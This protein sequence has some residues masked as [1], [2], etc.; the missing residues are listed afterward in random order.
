MSETIEKG[1]GIYD[2][3]E[4]GLAA[5][6]RLNNGISMPWLGLGVFQMGDDATTEA[7]V[8]QAIGMGY[9][10]IDTAALYGNERGVGQAVRNS[11][12]PRKDLFVTTKVWNDDLREDRVEAAFE[13]SLARLD[14]EYVDLYLIHWPV[15]GKFVSAWKVMEKIYRSGRAKAIGVSNFLIP[16]LE[17]LLPAAEIVPTVNQI[18]FHPYLQSTSLQQYCRERN[19]RLTAWSPLMQ[20]TLLE[21]P[22]IQKIA[23]KQGKTPAQIVLRWDLQSGV[24]TIPKSSRVE[25][26]QENASIFD[27]ELSANDMEALNALERNQRSGADPMDFDF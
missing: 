14:L 17:A 15:E 10:S 3:M 9:R 25:R 1:P 11:G 16:Q 21:D 24:I 13:E 7:C 18:E 27:F 4:A 8:R 22:V 20:G 12:V 5:R 6:C 19:I 26:M 23:E 2:T